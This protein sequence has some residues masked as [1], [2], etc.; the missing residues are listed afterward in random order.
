MAVS[1]RRVAADDWREMKRV[2]LAA[3][4]T[5]R[6]AFGSTLEAEAAFGD[7]VWIERARESATSEHRV[8][9]V[10]CAEDGR[11]IG[12]VGAHI[13]ERG[14]SLFGMW[15]DPAARGAGVGGKMLDALIGWLEVRHRE[16]TISL[17]VNPALGAAVRLYESRGF[18]STGASTAIDH[19]PG[20]RCAEMVRRRSIS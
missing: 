8:T 10:A 6:V 9:W 4:A 18:T 19:T 15:V 20:A 17:S 5:D 2:R 3:L 7:E 13:E 16:A 14:A 12:M 11:M 1:V